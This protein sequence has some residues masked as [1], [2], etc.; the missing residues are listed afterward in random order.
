MSRKKASSPRKKMRMLHLATLLPTEPQALYTH[1]LASWTRIKVHFTA[2]PANTV[3]A[4]LTALNTALGNGPGGSP[5]DTAVIV[6]AAAKV[7]QDWKQ[8]AAYVEGALLAGPIE[9]VPAILAEILMY[10][11]KVGLRAPKPELQAKQPKGTLSGVVLL[12]ALA[13]P[14]AVLYYWEYSVDGVSWTAAGQCAQAH[15]TIAGLTAGKVYSFRF[16]TFQRAGTLTGLSQVITY[17]VR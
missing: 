13:V 4:D 6:A 2:V 11:S 9:A 7:R 16:H 5:A 3:D 10:E 12:V 8:V 1:C 17:M 15:F 14:S